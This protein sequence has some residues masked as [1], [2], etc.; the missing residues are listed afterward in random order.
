MLGVPKEL[1]SHIFKTKLVENTKERGKGNYFLIAFCLIEV[2]G[3][4][5]GRAMK[6]LRQ[7]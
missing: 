7:V 5:R 6:K 2:A 1:P 4:R 3:L